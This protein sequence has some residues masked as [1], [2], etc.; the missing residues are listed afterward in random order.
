MASRLP[1][2]LQIFKLRTSWQLEAM[3]AGWGVCGVPVGSPAMLLHHSLFGGL[4]QVRID[5]MIATAPFS[6]SL[7]LSG[8]FQEHRVQ[9]YTAEHGASCLVDTPFF[10]IL[11]DPLTLP[12]SSRHTIIFFF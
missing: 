12:P 9:L 4:D 2:V 6:L 5:T 10:P 8:F 7:S 3:V 1:L 11:C